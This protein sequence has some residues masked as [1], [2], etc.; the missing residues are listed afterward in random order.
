MELDYRDSSEVWIHGSDPIRLMKDDVV[1]MLT[2]LASMSLDE[3]E[4]PNTPQYIASECLHLVL[5]HLVHDLDDAD[6]TRAA[7]VM[8]KAVTDAVLDA[9][10][11]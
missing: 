11:A 9:Y 6:S 1:E 2:S 7:D 5:L 10:G 3:D 4:Q 8:I